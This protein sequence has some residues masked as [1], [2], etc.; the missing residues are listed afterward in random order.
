MT[1]GEDDD[2]SGETP[3]EFTV[4]QKAM[5]ADMAARP[6]E[7]LVGAK[8]HWLRLGEPFG[9]DAAAAVQAEFEARQG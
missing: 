1:G 9:E 8:A 3:D 7:M 4:W 6:R 5:A 2:D